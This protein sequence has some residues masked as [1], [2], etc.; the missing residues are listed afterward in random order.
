MT[1]LQGVVIVPVMDAGFAESLHAE[2]RPIRQ[3][4]PRGGRGM[5]QTRVQ[6]AV[7]VGLKH[8]AA[9]MTK[10]PLGDRGVSG[11]LRQH[12]GHR[13]SQPCAGAEESPYWPVRSPE[14]LPLVEI[15]VAFFQVVPPKMLA[16]RQAEL[17]GFV[18]HARSF[19]RHHVA[20][21]NAVVVR[22]HLQRVRRARSGGASRRFSRRCS[23][24]PPSS[25][26]RSRGRFHSLCTDR[27]CRVPRPRRGSRHPRDPDRG[28]LNDRLLLERDGIL[29]SG[30]AVQ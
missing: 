9:V 7:A 20:E 26:P 15:L 19:A 21:R 23:C 27:P 10:S 12:E 18:R 22:P 6:A 4:L 11:T 16:R 2:L 30:V 14:G 24:Q 13:R 5:A 28:S 29:Q 8:H 17:R 1:T 25:E 3:K